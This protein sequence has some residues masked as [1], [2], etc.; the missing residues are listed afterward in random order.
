MVSAKTEVEKTEKREITIA[1][2]RKRAKNFILS[3][4]DFYLV[5]NKPYCSRKPPKLIYCKAKI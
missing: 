5:V 3:L 2:S 1:T 4:K